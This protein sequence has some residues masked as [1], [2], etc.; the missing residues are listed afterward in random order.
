MAVEPLHVP[1]CPAASRGPAGPAAILTSGEG[2]NQFVT[3]GGRDDWK[4][5]TVAT[6]AFVFSAEF[7]VISRRKKKNDLMGKT[8]M[9]VI[10]QE[11]GRRPSLHQRSKDTNNISRPASVSPSPPP[12]V[13]LL[14]LQ[15]NFCFVLFCFS[16]L[17]SARRAR[18]FTFKGPK[19][20]GQKKNKKTP[21]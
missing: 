5:P 12:S 3:C 11:A 10:V 4:C 2:A 20:S 16:Q 13:V 9:W 7:L 19:S 6:V 14:Q 8:G 15:L 21:H 1:V 18:C 17:Y